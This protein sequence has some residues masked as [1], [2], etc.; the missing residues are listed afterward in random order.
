MKIFNLEDEMREALKEALNR[1]LEAFEDAVEVVKPIVKDVR[2]K[3]DI[4]VKMY[5]KKF[6]KIANDYEIRVSRSEINEA[7]S[8]VDREFIE[9]L[10]IAI[11][12]VRKFHEEER[13]RPWIKE[14]ARGVKVG[15]L[16][17]PIE[18][19]GLYI[20]G[21]RAPYPST[22]VMTCVP[23]KVA[24][25]SKVV[26]CTP[27]GPDGKLNPYV[28][29]ALNESGVDE[30]YKAGGAQ[31]IAA[32][33]YGTE[34]ITKV[35]VVAGPGNIYV[36]AA[37]YL[38]SN[39]VGIDVLAGPSELLVIAD[40]SADPKLIALDLASQ[41]EHDPLA[42][43]ALATTNLRIARDVVEELKLMAE[44]NLI[45]KDVLEKHFIVVYGDPKKLV[46]FANAYAPEHLQ[47]MVSKPEEYVNEIRASGVLLVG[48]NT[49]TALSDYC[50]GPSHVLPTGRCSRFR[51][52][53]STL[54]FTKFMHY[55]EVDEL[56]EKIFRAAIK[57]AEVEGFKLHAEALKRR[58]KS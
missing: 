22:A 8:R 45:V 31:A 34:S 40:E 47:L 3:G 2:D 12:M 57:L 19:A 38:V 48:V 50:A 13:P 30:V 52:G 28:L 58:L 54:T 46:D 25:V 51:S 6:S 11:D 26:A 36:T 18:I 15:V 5:D 1:E 24:G 7:Y 42:Q 43:I 21:G 49:P 17:R 16:P 10:R 44:E 14:I 35:D 9:A 20:P 27:P 23:A 32:M 33:A 56:N 29:V 41:A 4:A 55:V 37:K 39:V 53:V